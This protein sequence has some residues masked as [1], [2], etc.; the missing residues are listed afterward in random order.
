MPSVHRD[1]AGGE[2]LALCP[3]RRPG[4]AGRRRPGRAAGGRRTA[5]SAMPSSSAARMIS[6]PLGTLISKPSMV[7]VTRSTVSTGPARRACPGS[8]AVR[9]EAAN[10][11]AAAGSNGQPPCS[12]C[13][14]YSSRKYLIVE[15]DRAACAPSPSAQNTRP[16]MLSHDVE[17]RGQVVLAALAR[18][19]ALRAAAASSTCPRGTACTCRTT[20]ARRTPSSA[21]RRGPRRW[22][23]RRSAARGCRAWSPAA[24]T[25]S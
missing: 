4:T 7:R 12:R 22:S 3:R 11:L 6:V 13:S 19:Q 1:G 20:R 16:T 21:A 15:A 8:S 9:S 23:R 25:A 10:R 18:F 14:R 5:G 17:Q 24:A 2:R